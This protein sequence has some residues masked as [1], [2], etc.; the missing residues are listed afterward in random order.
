MSLKEAVIY[1]GEEQVANIFP[2]DHKVCRTELIS[3]SCKTLENLICDGDLMWAPVPDPGY[4]SVD[5][6][7]L[8]LDVINS[9]RVSK[10][11]SK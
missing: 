3:T 8:N 4:K 7:D 10:S 2:L 1:Y 5:G 9:M 6:R 11:K